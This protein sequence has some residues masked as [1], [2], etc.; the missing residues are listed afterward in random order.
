MAC[1]GR[2]YI[3]LALGFA[4]MLLP[5][6]AQADMA[7]FTDKVVNKT[8]NVA[9][10]VG[11]GVEKAATKTGEKIERAGAKIQ[12]G[13][14]RSS[15]KAQD[16]VVRASDKID[17]K[18][19]PIQ[20][21]LA[22]NEYVLTRHSELRASPSPRARVHGT[23]KAGA[24]VVVDDWSDDGRWGHVRIRHEGRVHDGWVPRASL[25]KVD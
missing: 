12:S 20:D 19:Q 18:A 25:K 13:A 21:K 7:E 6:M 11:D 1:R 10:K 23:F 3:S 14:S 2:G 5:A 8:K 9:T 24:K 16:G 22:Q 17:G 4:F 15:A